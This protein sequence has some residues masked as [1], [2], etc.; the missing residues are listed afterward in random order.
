MLVWGVKIETR[1]LIGEGKQKRGGEL[2][3]GAVNQ[4]LAILVSIFGGRRSISWG[5]LW[6]LHHTPS[7]FFFLF[8]LLTYCDVS[9]HPLTFEQ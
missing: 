7:L 9:E 1:E 8:F 4:G 6:M 3:R 2:G 5:L